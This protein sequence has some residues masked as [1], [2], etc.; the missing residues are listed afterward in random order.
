MIH[1]NQSMFTGLGLPLPGT[2]K[3]ISYEGVM[4][5]GLESNMLIHLRNKTLSAISIMQKSMNRKN[6]VK[7]KRMYNCFSVLPDCNK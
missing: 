5:R 6:A 7:Q 4:S 1:N 2:S 3:D